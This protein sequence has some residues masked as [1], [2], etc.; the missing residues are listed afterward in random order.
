MIAGVEFKELEIVLGKKLK[1]FSDGYSSIKYTTI[2]KVEHEIHKGILIDR[3]IDFIVSK[4][5][6][7]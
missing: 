5:G 4:L 7:K 6:L 3:Y 2:D 1:S